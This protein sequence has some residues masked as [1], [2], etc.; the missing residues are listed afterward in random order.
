MHTHNDTKP[1]QCDL[2]GKGF[3]RNFD[4][5]KHVRKLHDK[6]HSQNRHRLTDEDDEKDDVESGIHTPIDDESDDNTN[7][8]SPSVDVLTFKNCS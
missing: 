4:L 6:D 8:S 5:K 7:E 1:F 3:C 2:C